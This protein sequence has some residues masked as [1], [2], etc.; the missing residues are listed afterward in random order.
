V[1]IAPLTK[2]GS[3]SNENKPRGYKN[4]QGKKKSGGS[5]SGRGKSHC[6]LKGNKGF[7]EQK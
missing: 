3:T 5:P 4:S 1:G 6:H 7:L 2:E